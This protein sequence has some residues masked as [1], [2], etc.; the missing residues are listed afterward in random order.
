[1]DDK[2]NSNT[3]K[4]IQNINNFS[5]PIKYDINKK[6]QINNIKG[7]N[8]EL[9]SNQKNYYENVILELSNKLT[10]S[11]ENFIYN[12]YLILYY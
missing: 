1:M 3:E 4:I 9:K 11:K 6:E 8:N 5:E 10:K 7:D 2:I 12:S